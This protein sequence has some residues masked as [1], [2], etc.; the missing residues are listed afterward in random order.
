MRT[1]IIID[2][3]YLDKITGNMGNVKFNYQ[4]LAEEL[5]IGDEL[6][7]VNYYH[8]LPLK[9]EHSPADKVDY[10]AS[11][12]RFFDALGHIPKFQVK[13]GKLMFRGVNQRGEEIYEQKR[14]DTMLAVD[15]VNM[16]IKKE[17]DR[18]VLISGDSDHIP[19]IEVVLKEGTIVSLYHG[20]FNSKTSPSLELYDLC[21]YKST[22]EN[23]IRQIV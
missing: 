7:T 19:A 21:P 4:K 10:F 14:V 3:G 6:V 2:G 23:I 11:K 17:V 13:L 9:N 22:L 5:T 1:A 15:M 8:C 20:S 18:I 16:S 12:Y